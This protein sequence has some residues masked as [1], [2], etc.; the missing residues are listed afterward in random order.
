MTLSLGIPR[1]FGVGRGVKL[2]SLTHCRVQLNFGL[3][4]FLDLSHD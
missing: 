2:Y 1:K 3:S 4:S